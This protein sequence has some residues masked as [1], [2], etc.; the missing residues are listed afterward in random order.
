M[1]AATR[2]MSALAGCLART[3]TAER[4][5]D[6]LARAFQLSPTLF[7][8]VEEAR[9]SVVLTGLASVAEKAGS[10]L[11]LDVELAGASFLL[12]VS[13]SLA[14]IALTLSKIHSLLL[15]KLT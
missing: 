1:L 10:Q 9:K 6:P 7:C 5:P 2:N 13:T 8:G 15:S 14:G 4:Y 11:L 12:T 3:P